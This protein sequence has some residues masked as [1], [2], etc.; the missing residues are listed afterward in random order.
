MNLYSISIFVIF[1]T[2]K[3]YR[4]LGAHYEERIQPVEDGTC[5][6][7]ETWMLETKRRRHSRL[8]QRQFDFEGC[9]KI[10]QLQPMHWSMMPFGPH[11]IGQKKSL[12]HLKSFLLRRLHCKISRP[13]NS[14]NRVGDDDENLLSR[15]VH[16][17]HDVLQSH[18]LFHSLPHDYYWTHL[19]YYC[20]PWMKMSI[21]V[22]AGL[23]RMEFSVW[24][25]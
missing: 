6:C 24:M 21:L 3:P 15:I 10:Q 22:I 11:C 5:Y 12:L 1:R 23:Q 4:A 7:W 16:G 9:Q 20:F 25:L 8:L 19:V 2:W 17:G 13:R 14:S 18:D